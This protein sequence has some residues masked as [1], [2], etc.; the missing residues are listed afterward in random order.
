M[1]F[2]DYRAEGAF[3]VS[4]S[5]KAGKTEFVRIKSLAGEPCIV[6][7][8]MEGKLLVKGPKRIKAVKISDDCYKLNIEKGDEVILYPEGTDPDLKIAAMP[9]AEDK[10]NYFGVKL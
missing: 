1:A 10:K 5:R 3:L 6:K 7:T 9:I 8:S 4:A 2:H